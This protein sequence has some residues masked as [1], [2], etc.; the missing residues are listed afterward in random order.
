MVINRGMRRENQNWVA[1]S[2]G[3]EPK[4]L[5]LK[6]LTHLLIG[7]QAAASTGAKAHLRQQLCTDAAGVTKGSQLLDSFLQGADVSGSYSSMKVSQQ[8]ACDATLKCMNRRATIHAS[9]TITLCTQVA[10]YVICQEY[11]RQTHPHSC[12]SSPQPLSESFITCSCLHCLATKWSSSVTHLAALLVLLGQVDGLAEHSLG[13]LSAR[14]RSR[15][16][17]HCR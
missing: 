12:T 15:L 11:S 10:T 17:H 4:N 3:R 2:L 13:L 6:G 5:S 7:P 14:G 8:G 9:G 16:N 1:A